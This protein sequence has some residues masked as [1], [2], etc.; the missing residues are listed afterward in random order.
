MTVLVTGG[1]GYIG[2]HT[3]VA[4]LQSGRDVVVLD[5]LSNSVPCVAERIATITSFKPTFV[6][7][8]MRDAAL[9]DKIFAS[10]RVE[11]VVHFAGCKAVGESVAN[12]LKYYHTNVGGTL[13]LL[14]AMKKAGV[15]TLVFS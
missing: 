15:P 7:G 4:L 14:A 12:P 2:S 1:L 9:L 6:E 13:A 5:D 11:A 10:H 8:D 3:C